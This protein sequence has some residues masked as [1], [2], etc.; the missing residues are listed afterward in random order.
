MSTSG[1][2]HTADDSETTEN[3]K[4]IQQDSTTIHLVDLS[5]EQPTERAVVKFELVLESAERILRMV[6]RE[7][8]YEKRAKR[9]EW[10][11]SIFKWMAIVIA[12]SG[13][14]VAFVVIGL[15][16]KSS[17]PQLITSFASGA[18][19][20]ALLRVF[21]ENRRLAKPQITIRRQ[22]DEASDDSH[23]DAR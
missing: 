8:V 9:T 5:A 13:V 16:S 11:L 20:V 1:E 19:V 15:N 3:G 4:L 14:I 22:D 6:E 18:A 17:I 21:K 12:L 2:E 23:Q 7:Q 10:W